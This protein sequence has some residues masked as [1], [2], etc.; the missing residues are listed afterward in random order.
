MADL[1]QD[2]LNQPRDIPTPSPPPPTAPLTRESTSVE[3]AG[4]GS[5]AEAL[6]GV[7]AMVLAIVGLAG[8]FPLYL[9]A[10]AAIV[11]GAGV[12]L[13]GA[14]LGARFARFVSESSTGGPTAEM[15]NGLST[16]VFAGAATIVLGIL[17]LIG[18]A[19]APLL[20]VAAIVFGAALLM[21]AAATASFNR[22]VVDHQYG[23][24]EFARRA[25]GMMVSTTSGRRCSSAS[26]PS[27][28]ASS[29]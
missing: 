25:A 19:T 15:G 4:G 5:L 6:C 9:D 3:V 13:A 8:T 18:I 12:I 10:I 16:E 1:M 23:T 28:W 14:S 22:L 24:H 2:R 7:A 11:L 17:A 20:S 27:C 21:G 26:P 29:R